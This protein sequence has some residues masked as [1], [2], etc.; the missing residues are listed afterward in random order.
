MNLWD[1]AVAAYAREGSAEACLALQD[2]HDQNI[3]YLLWAAWAA[4]TGRPLDAETLEAGADTARAWS[5][6]AIAPLRAIR[7]TLKAPIPDIDDGARETLHARIKADELE[8]E[9]LLLAQ[10]EALAPAAAGPAA[11]TAPALIAAARTWSRVVPRG[12]LEAL[13]QKLSP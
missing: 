10:L 3:P 6:A 4:E 8:A 5:G 9:R 2:G 13:A 12:L 1:W 11:P 7:R